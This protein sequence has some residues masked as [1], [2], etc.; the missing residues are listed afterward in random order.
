MMRSVSVGL[1][2]SLGPV[3]IKSMAQIGHLAF[4]GIFICG[5]IGQVQVIC[6]WSGCWFCSCIICI[7]CCWICIEAVIISVKCSL[8]RAI[9]KF[10]FLW[11]SMLQVR[12]R[13][14][15]VC[16][17][18][19]WLYISVIVF[20]ASGLSCMDWRSARPSSALSFTRFTVPT[21]SA[22]SAFGIAAKALAEPGCGCPSV[23]VLSLVTRS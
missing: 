6:C 12:A 13:Q 17:A 21:K 2:C 4:W 19:I 7:I 1:V 20:I 16:I 14:L 23:R 9:S 8:G 15:W 10:A 11:S 5:C 18:V 3:G 22:F